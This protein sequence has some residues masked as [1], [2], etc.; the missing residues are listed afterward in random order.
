MIDL[1]SDT[2]TLPTE[3]MIEAMFSAKVGDDV[4]GEDPSI[5]TLEDKAAE[6]FGMDAG[7]YCPS[8]TMTNQIAI[9]CHVKPGEEVIC[10]KTAH[11]YN[12]EG[13]GIGANSGASV[14][15]IDGERGKIF[16]EQ[17]VD[18]V[19]P[20]DYHYPASK[21]VSIEN[22]S[23]KGGGSFYSIQQMIAIKEVCIQHNL[24]YH[25]DG[26]RIFNALVAMNE[27]S[28][29]LSGIFDSISICLSKGLGAPMGSLLL[30]S[31]DFIGNARRM[32]KMMGGGMRQAGYMASAG[33]YAIEN[34]IDR[35]KEDH[36]RAAELGSVI[37]NLSFVQEMQPIETNIVI[38]KLQES[39]GRDRFI[40][41]LKDNGI[42]VVP[43]GNQVVRMVTHMEITDSMINEVSN[44]LKSITK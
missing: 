23:N 34:H 22:T 25:L 7:L 42:L 31:K 33:I 26:A 38:F 14:R 16:P 11:I 40:S 5:N 17:I 18:S 44:I 39:M 24:A 30:G 20:Y 28:Q 3:P 4:F 13:G 29:S 15:L 1:R 35:L 12:Y 10:D 41:L 6:M 37:V 27:K 8:G 19:N 36:N 21:L 9:R 32:R 43:L 2:V